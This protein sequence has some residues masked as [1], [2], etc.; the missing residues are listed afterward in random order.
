MMAVLKF[1]QAIP[2]MTRAADWY[3]SLATLDTTDNDLPYLTLWDLL[4]HYI[5]KAT[6]DSTFSGTKK[7][8]LAN[9]I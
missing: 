8:E 3:D 6:I 7:V 4:T 2:A 1:G 9:L 5:T